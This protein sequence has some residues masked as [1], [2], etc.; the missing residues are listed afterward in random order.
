[1]HRPS[2]SYYLN[3]PFLL[4]CL[5]PTVKREREICLPKVKLL[6]DYSYKGKKKCSLPI[7]FLRLAFLRMFELKL[8]NLTCYEFFLSLIHN[9]PLC[10]F[11][12]TFKFAD[13]NYRC[14]HGAA[15]GEYDLQMAGGVGPSPKI[16]TLYCGEPREALSPNRQLQAQRTQIRLVSSDH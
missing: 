4:V 3:F 5:S 11:T 13:A 15:N 9:Q 7:F 2:I 12:S 16:S 1:M 6:I 10:I 8:F 14:K